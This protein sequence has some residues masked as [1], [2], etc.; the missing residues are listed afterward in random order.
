MLERSSQ[1]ATSVGASS[2]CVLVYLSLILAIYILSSVY[3]THLDRPH[4]HIYMAH[5]FKNL[6]NYT[7]CNSLYIHHYI[8]HI[9]T[10]LLDTVR[11]DHFYGMNYF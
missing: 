4:L 5:Y 9:L 1:M 10:R 8:G 7:V 11:E 6:L 2:S 3:Y